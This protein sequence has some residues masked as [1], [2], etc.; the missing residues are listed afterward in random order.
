MNRIDQATAEDRLAILEE[1]A[2]RLRYPPL[3]VEKDF[4]VCWVLGILFGQ[5]GGGDALVFKGGTS[6][7]KVFNVIERFSED[8]DLS[9][10]PAAIGI[11]E[12]EV[13]SARSRRQ[14]DER[15]HEL[16][17]RCAVWVRGKLAPQLEL[18]IRQALGPC[19]ARDD[20]LEYELDAVSQSPVLHFHYPSMFRDGAP[21]IR[22]AVKLEFGSLTDQRPAGVHRV[23]PWAAKA[24][25]SAAEE[26]G[27]NV[28]AM[29]AERTCW[30]KA[31]I[32]HAEH[33]RP[34]STPMPP[35]Y[36]RHYADMASLARSGSLTPALG[37][38]A[39]RQ[40]VVEWKSK[41]FARAWARYDLA[42]PGTFRLLPAESRMP[43]L[44]QDY[45]EMRDMFLATPP[46]FSAILTTLRDLEQSI[47]RNP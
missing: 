36:S 18:L 44:E 12:A 39:L 6:L 43:G 32:L 9:V 28:V 35:R 2:Q 38:E 26:M 27:C 22:R 41:F 7:S 17:K 31:T 21:Y 5:A 16:E 33:H 3:V 13:E 20:W 40:R 14:R 29:E 19:A 46:P 11:S 8:I 47:N 34:A 30:E 4:W 1:A 37:D 23:R 10:S 45:R 15:M 42:V 25:P 24:L